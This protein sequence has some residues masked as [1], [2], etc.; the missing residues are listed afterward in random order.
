[1]RRYLSLAVTAGLLLSANLATA[2]T[3][4]QGNVVPNDSLTHP[5]LSAKS[6]YKLAGSGDYQV[7]LKGITDSAG[8][9]AAVTTGTTPD[10]QYWA[11]LK[12]D[13]NGVLWQLNV[14]FNITKAGQ[15]KIKGSNSLIT[16]VD[17]GS[18]VGVLGVEIRE[19]TTAGT[20]ANCTTLM[21][22]PMLPGVFLPGL[23]FATNPCASGARV[24]ISG[25]VTE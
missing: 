5:Q 16:S 2:G 20:A 15:A 6:K 10:T 23:P 24:G 4:V 12:G 3:K 17:V 13:A 1:M 9:P 11:I 14:P 25:V 22:D 21:N 7:N 18:A 19:P 8:M